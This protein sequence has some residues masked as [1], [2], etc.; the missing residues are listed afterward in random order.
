LPLVAV[1]QVSIRAEPVDVRDHT[2]V[3]ERDDCIVDEEASGMRGVENVMVRIF[4]T[5]TI[6]IGGRERASVEWHGIDWGTLLS[7][8]FNSRFV[9]NDFEGDISGCFRLP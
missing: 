3:F 2:R 1:K 7:R 5:G 8:T 6:E 9:F 4:R